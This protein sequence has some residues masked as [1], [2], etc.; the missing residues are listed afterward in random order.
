MR[1]RSNTD[2]GAVRGRVHPRSAMMP[3][4]ILT[5]TTDPQGGRIVLL[6]RVWEWKIL[7]DPSSWSE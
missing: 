7:R 6:R 3:E 2:V 4:E 1:L 5:E